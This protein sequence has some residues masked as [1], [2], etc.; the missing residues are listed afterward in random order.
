MIADVVDPNN[1]IKTY[2]EDMNGT[3]VEWDA[4][5]QAIGEVKFSHVI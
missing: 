3:I 1:G 4:E 5:L 2:I